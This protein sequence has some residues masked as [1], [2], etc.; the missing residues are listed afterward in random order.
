M[1]Q[2]EGLILVGLDNSL[3]RPYL[4]LGKSGNWVMMMMMMMMMSELVFGLNKL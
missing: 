3:V 4:F 2:N 1:L